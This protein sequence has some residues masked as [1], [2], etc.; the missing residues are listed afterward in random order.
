MK[1]LRDLKYFLGIGVARSKHGIF[2][3]QR[4]YILDLLAKTRV[5]RC[6][7]IDTPIEQNHKNFH[8]DDATSAYRGRYQRLV[9]KLI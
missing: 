2:L 1:Q 6:K 3:S 7:P 9:G 8:C 5:L 4:K